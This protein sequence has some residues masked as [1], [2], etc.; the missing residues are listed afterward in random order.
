MGVRI[1]LINDVAG[2]SYVHSQTWKKAYVDYI[3]ADYLENISDDGWIPLFAKALTDKI[4]DAAVFELDGIITGTITFGRERKRQNSLYK[5]NGI[6]QIN[7][8]GEIISLYVLPEYWATK[9]GYELMKFAVENLRQQGFKS[10]FLWVIRENERAIRFYR[11]FGFTS[12]NELLTVNMAG[13]P[14]VE[15][16]YRIML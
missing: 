7:S 14:L 2:M 16:K 5:E 11:R 9:Q 1:A 15:E 13:R 6:E 10:C 3:S 4:H 8:E 12:T